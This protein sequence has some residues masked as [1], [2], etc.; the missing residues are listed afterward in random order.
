MAAAQAGLVHCSSQSR[1]MD[2]QSLVLPWSGCAGCL[3]ALLT[4]KWPTALQYHEKSCIRCMDIQ[5]DQFDGLP[6]TSSPSRTGTA[7]HLDK[8]V[9]GVQAK[10]VMSVGSSWRA[11]I[12]P[13]SCINVEAR[14]H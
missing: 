5:A 6:P 14:L 11:G 7:H 9:P 2:K 10:S 3:Q 13:G 1:S 8:V 4:A 12:S